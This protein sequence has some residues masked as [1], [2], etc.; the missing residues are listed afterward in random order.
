M[1]VVAAK[2]IVKKKNQSALGL[3]STTAFVIHCISLYHLPAMYTVLISVKISVAVYSFPQTIVTGGTYYFDTYRKT[4][5]VIPTASKRSSFTE[6]DRLHHGPVPSC[7]LNKPG[8]RA[9][10]ARRLAV[11]D[12]QQTHKE[13][14]RK[15]YSGIESL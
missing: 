12:C 10:F 13:T 3:V 8:P 6:F 9:R 15:R 11:S 5:L 1:L 2:Q 4:T 7:L 14:K